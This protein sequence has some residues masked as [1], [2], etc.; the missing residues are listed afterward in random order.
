MMRILINAYSLTTGGGK[1]ILKDFLQSLCA[2]APEKKLIF[3]VCVAS[4]SEYAVFE[5]DYITFFELPPLLRKKYLQPM[6]RYYLARQIQKRKIDKVFS[7]GNIALPTDRPQL[8][9]FHWAYAVYPEK[10][11]WSNMDIKSYLN[12]KIRLSLFQKNLK[13]ATTV[14]AQT[15]NI[16]ERLRRYYGLENIVTIPNSVAIN[17]HPAGHHRSFDLPEGKKLLYLTHYYTHKNLEIFIPLAKKIQERNLDYKLITTISD[18]QHPLAKKFLQDVAKLG[19]Q[20]VIHNIGPVKLEETASL[21]RQ[22]DALLMPTLLESFGITYIEAMHFKLPILTSERDFAR[23]V[24]QDSAFYFDPL[25]SADILHTIQNAFSGTGTLEV[26]TAQYA[27]LL[28]GFPS[29]DA[30]AKKYVE[31]MIRL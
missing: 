7:M 31:E 30:V 4:R 29:S 18:K 9:L 22:C 5:N 23:A 20:D 17:S 10:V 24:C 21:Y 12:R 2:I 1:R 25:D 11:I 8:L 15:S 16:E 13:Y 27:L 6:V 28:D 3:Y 26:K 19:L 14:I